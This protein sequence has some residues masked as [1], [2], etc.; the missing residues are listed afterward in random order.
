MRDASAQNAKK[1]HKVLVVST[2]VSVASVGKAS[3]SAGVGIAPWA[4]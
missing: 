2:R 1:A 3:S 4:T